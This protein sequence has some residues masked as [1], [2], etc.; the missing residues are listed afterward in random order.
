[1]DAEPGRLFRERE[2]ITTIAPELEWTESGWAGYAPV[3]PFERPKPPQLDAFL[4]G[5]RL[6]LKVEYLQSYP[7]VAPRFVPIDPEPDLRVRTMHDWHV[8]GDGSLCMFQ[9]ST[10][11]DPRSTAADL[12]PKASGWFLEYLLLTG[13][14]IE[15]MTVNGIVSDDVLDHLFVAS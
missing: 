11:W 10:D 14:L 15:H 4:A 8:N 6:Q 12:I 3:W 7:M 5:R 1:M 2:A 13:E 9:N